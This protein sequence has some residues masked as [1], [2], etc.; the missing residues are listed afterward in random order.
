MFTVNDLSF[1]MATDICLFA[2]DTTLFDSDTY[3]QRL[4]SKFKSKL[5][6]QLE[7]V[8]FNRLT[9]NWDKTK[10]MCMSSKRKTF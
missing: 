9:I 3:L 6:L 2:D 1:N 5:A 8:K 7:W 4:I 10:F